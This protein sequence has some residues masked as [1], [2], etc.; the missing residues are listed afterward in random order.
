MATIPATIER[1]ACTGMTPDWISGELADNSRSPAA[2]RL[3]PAWRTLASFRARPTPSFPL[4]P[5]AC[6]GDV[7]GLFRGASWTSGL[8]FTNWDWASTSS[9]FRDNAV[10][11]EVLPDLTEADLQQLGIPLGHRKRLLKAIAGLSESPQPPHTDPPAPKPPRPA[12]A[13]PVA[14]RDD[15][16]RRPITVMFC[17]LVGSTSMAAKLDAED[18]RDLVSAYLDEASKAVAGYGGHVLKKLGDGLMALFGYPRAQEND[19]ERAA[20]AGLAILRALEELNVR[21]AARALPS[22][23]ARI[24]LETGPV[25]VDASGEVFGDAPNVAARVQSAAEPG[26]LWVTAGVQRQVA[27]LFVAE[28]KGP[29]ELKGVAGKPVLYRLV[30]ASGASRRTAGRALTLLVGRED[31][32]AQLAR[33]WERARSGEGQFVQIIGEPGL[34]KS[35]LIEEVRVTLAETPHTWIEWASSQLLQNTPLHPLSE[36]GRQRFGGEA[37]LA[38]LE[39]TL[40]SVKLD[41]NEYAPLLA[42]LLDIPV[43]EDREPKLTPEELRRRQLAAIVA[44]IMAGA[45]TQSIVLVVEDLHWADPTTLDLMK[46]L[47]ERSAQAPL[48]VVTTARPEFRAPWATRSH[49]AVISLVPLDR[50]EIFKMVGAI[51]AKHALTKDVVEGL[52]DRTAGVPLFV[53]ELTRLMLEGGVQTIPP[54]LQQSLAARLD[55]LGDAREVAQI[56]AV[57]GREFSHELLTAVAGMAEPAI[58]AALEKLADADLLFVEGTAPEATYRFKHALIQDAAYESLLKNRRQALHRR[59]AEALV[60]ASNPQPELVA[61]HFTQSNQTELAIEWWG[62]AGDTALSRSAFQEAISHLGKAIELSDREGRPASLSAPA[63]TV[64]RLKL[65]TSYGKAVAWS[66]GFAAEETKAALTRTERL[67][68]QSDNV[69]ERMKARYARW[70]ALN[71]SGRLEMARDAAEIYLREAKLAGDARAVASAGRALGATYF[72]QGQFEEA[73]RNLHAALGL[74]N[75]DRESTAR[76]PRRSEAEI[77]AKCYIAQIAWFMGDATGAAVQFEEALTEAVASEYAPTI[78]N[79]YAHEATHAVARGDGEVTIRAA[80][81]LLD[82]SV[83]SG[84]QLYE[85][86]ARACLSW[87]RSR[88]GDKDELPRFQRLSETVI[89]QFGRL[90]GPLLLGRLAEI[91]ADQIS[92]ETALTS[93][94]RALE[95]ARD[96]DIRYLD[97]LLH[98]IRGGILLRRDPAN[99]VLTEEAYR[100]AIAIGREQGARTFELQAALPLAKLLQSTNRRLEAPDVLAPAL[101]GFAPTPELPAIAEAQALFQ[102]L[103]ADE[104]VKTEAA[105]RARRLKLQTSYGQAVMWSKGYGAEETKAAFARVEELATANGDP[106]SPFDAYYGR[107]ARSVFGGDLGSARETAESFVRIAER[108]ERLTE[109]GVG[110]RLLGMTLFLLGDFGQARAQCEQAVRTYNPDRDRDAKFRFGQ[111]SAV[112]AVAYLTLAGWCVGDVTRARELSDD[113]RARAIECAHAPTLANTYFTIATVEALRDDA[114]AARGAVES[115]VALSREHGLALNLAYGAL[116]SAWAQAKRGARNAGSTELRMALAEYA[117]TGVKFGGPFFRGLLAEIEG[118]G[119]D[120]EAALAEIDGALALA[121][122][123][124]EHWF[125]AGLHRIR[126]EILLKQNPAD[127]AAAVTAFLAAIAVA[128]QQKAR[129]FELLAALALAKLLTA[130]VRLV[131]AHNVL[132]PALEGFA[133]SPELPAIAEAQALLAKLIES[134]KVRPA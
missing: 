107:W 28:D 44:W 22:L 97:A 52:S 8:G 61:H 91:E 9:A 24:G 122:E 77:S 94:D 79:A 69:A 75:L 111:D 37:R 66:K 99:T 7:E 10:D 2:W 121:G 59:A 93:I 114:E 39:A 45:R 125:D 56:G 42:P 16:E 46:T 113:A 6:I 84:L 74:Y 127:P 134:G 104:S 131:E 90:F 25:V 14:A 19:A 1:V 67:L 115:G 41:P 120:A 82:V 86:A 35:R 38:D 109:A 5:F 101:E 36:W 58:G 13:P 98:R 11:F 27:G 31:E 118:V 18:W 54:T 29:H 116:L 88:Q 30:R 133:P 117:G 12:A 68:T 83:K 119:A 60:A 124:G 50:V 49:H 92:A 128:Q 73:G 64:Q 106:Q 17:D 110:H 85:S 47:A 55:R 62:K 129:T 53:E 105:R 23:A 78:C 71:T 81:V 103:A 32:L 3:Q 95:F 15:A 51:A 72:Y 70:L 132:A 89:S 126:G 96:G 76:R 33:R 112:G 40:S 100:T 130:N 63:P 108:D 34:G 20:R 26:A 87:A 4:D 48:L 80:T 65:Q 43:P 57:L 123:T 102:V 21:H